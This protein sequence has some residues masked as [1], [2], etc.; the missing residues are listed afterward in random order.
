M[1][2]SDI[3]DSLVADGCRVLDSTL[4][5]CVLGSCTYI[6]HGCTIEDSLLFGADTFET[7]AQR[8]ACSVAASG[9]PALGIGAGSTVRRAVVDR[10]ARIGAGCALVN[11]A[12]VV[13]GDADALPN[14]IVI[15][16][17]LVIVTRDAIVPAG[18]KV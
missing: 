15:R 5:G 12:G 16:E 7:P 3:D 10:N 8:A 17:G 18:T 6:D 11:A 4:K 14:G 9:L 13:E 2:G 1:H